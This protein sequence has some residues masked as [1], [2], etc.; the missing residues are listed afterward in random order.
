MKKKTL[1]DSY[2]VVRTPPKNIHQEDLKIFQHEFNREFS[3]V[4]LSELKNV[5]ITCD[6]FVY[7]HNDLMKVS[8][9]SEK[10]YKDGR[11]KVN[12]QQTLIRRNL[13]KDL[14]SVDKGIYF[15]DT[16]S[17]GYFH[18]ILDTLPR[19]YLVK[20]YLQQYPVILPYYYK[21]YSYIVNSLK[22]FD[23]D[24]QYIEKNE[25]LFLENLLIPEHVAP[26]GNYNPSLLFELKKF[27]LNKIDN[28][29]I[30]G[31][32]KIYVSRAKANRF[33]RKVINEPDIFPVLKEHNYRITYFEDLNWFDQ[34]K[35]MANSNQLISIHGAGLANMLFMPANSKILEIRR[36]GDSHQNC[37]FS[38][39]SALGYDYY[40]L[41]CSTKGF[42]KNTMRGNLHVDP[43]EFSD[44]LSLMNKS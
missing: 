13:N 24:I 27:I 14:R 18:W 38:L 19:L 10:S 5:K 28:H 41:L 15:I 35:L 4:N 39:A 42:F 8:F 29:H 30:S 44:V 20:D 6:G 26:S 7:Q 11:K 34:I 32:G 16:R 23:A 3:H 43:A 31:Q 1:I 2:E 40:Y 17:T 12:F 22:L 25:C 36:K 9:P 33:R 21:D 37:F